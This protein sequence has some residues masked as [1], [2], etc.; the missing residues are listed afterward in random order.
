MTGLCLKII[1]TRGPCTS[2]MQQRRVEGSY[3][4]RASMRDVTPRRMEATGFLLLEKI[5]IISPGPDVPACYKKQCAPGDRLSTPPC[6]AFLY[7]IENS[8]RKIQE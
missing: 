4:P 7:R 8:V 3:I 6:N 5:V 2:E 1:K